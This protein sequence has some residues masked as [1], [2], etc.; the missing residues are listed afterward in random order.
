MTLKPFKI[1]KLIYLELDYLKEMDSGNTYSRKLWGCILFKY[2]DFCNSLF[3]S[4]CGCCRRCNNDGSNHY[5]V[6]NFI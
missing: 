1:T 3:G 5:G 6:V 2:A 4:Y